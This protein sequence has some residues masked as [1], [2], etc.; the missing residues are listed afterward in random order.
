MKIVNIVLSILILLLAVASAVF[1]YFLFEKR[2]QMVKGWGKMAVIVNQTSA[3][4]D[5][6]S[7]T[8][9]AKS[10]S[11]E[12]LSHEKYSELDKNLTQ[13]IQ[14]A[15]KI[16]QQRDDLG[17][18]IKKI[19]TVTEMKTIPNSDAFINLDAYVGA[20]KNVLDWIVES[21]ERQDGIIRQICDTASKLDVSIT[22]DALRTPE[23]SGEMRKLDTKIM[24][25]QSR[26]SNYNDCFTRLAK[27]LGDS[28]PSFDD[29]T[30]STSINSIAVAAQKIKNELNSAKSS[31]ANTQ[32]EL[33][34]MQSTVNDKKSSIETLQRDLKG[35][36]DQITKLKLIINPSG[37]GLKDDFKLWTEGS[38]EARMA[39]QGKIIDINRKY[40]FVVVDLGANTKVEQAIGNK[41][42]PVNPKIT[43]NIDVVVARGLEGDN[44][45]YVGKLK[46]IKVHDN[47]S[48]ANIIPG[49]TG[50]REVKIGDTVYLSSDAV[51]AMSK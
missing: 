48:I 45:Q 7:G 12:L 39:V 29:N 16:V 20:K 28:N 14:Q 13:L 41:I 51:A 1:S 43:S 50:D 10:L 25:V 24:A 34:S 19:A 3:E 37:T 17:S 33:A 42:N 5:K 30:Y 36:D 44:T 23:Y 18:T 26:I 4:L 9:I 49:S 40:G 21:K 6:G 11:P 38:P 2:E 47:C 27:T 32:K 22:A 8:N 46:I 15:Q 31:L 35:R